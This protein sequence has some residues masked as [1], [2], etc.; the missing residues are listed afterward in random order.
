[1]RLLKGSIV[2][3]LQAVHFK[4]EQEL[5]NRPVRCSVQQCRGVLGQAF[6]AYCSRSLEHIAARL[7]A[8]LTHIHSAYAGPMYVKSVNVAKDCWQLI[9]LGCSEAIPI[10][11]WTYRE[12]ILRP[13]EDTVVPLYMRHLHPSYQTHLQPHVHRLRIQWIAVRNTDTMANLDAYFDLLVRKCH[14]LLYRIYVDVPFFLFWAWRVLLA[15]LYRARWHLKVAV[16]KAATQVADSRVFGSALSVNDIEASLNMLISLALGLALWRARNAIIR[17]VKACLAVACWPMFAVKRIATWPFSRNTA[18]TGTSR[19]ADADERVPDPP[20][21]TSS[22]SAGTDTATA[23]ATAASS[24]RPHRSPTRRPPAPPSSPQPP[25]PVSE[26]P[27]HPSPPPPPPRPP[28]PP[29]RK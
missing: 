28:P 16:F 12:C 27:S 24:V 17:I 3:C 19:A 26:P 22:G 10:F 18:E 4:V 1:M 5:L 15:L 14:W 11:D 21:H 29:P 7:R 13:Y 20:A 6:S 23:T 8:V 2:S 9:Q 25:A